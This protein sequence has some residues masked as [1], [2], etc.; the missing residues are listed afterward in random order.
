MKQLLVLVPAQTH[1]TND[2]DEEPANL[3]MAKNMTGYV[4]VCQLTT[5]HKPQTRHTIDEKPKRR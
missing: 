5:E 1:T 2:S 4:K 3:E